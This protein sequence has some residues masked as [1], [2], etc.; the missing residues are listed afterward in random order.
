MSFA[1][2][3][4]RNRS[5]FRNLIE[6]SIKDYIYGSFE[7]RKCNQYPKSGRTRTWGTSHFWVQTQKVDIDGIRGTVLVDAFDAID[8]PFDRLNQ[9]EIKSAI[10]NGAGLLVT[11]QGAIQSPLITNKITDTKTLERFKFDLRNR[12]DLAV[13]IAFDKEGYLVRGEVLPLC[14]TAEWTA[15]GLD[16]EQR[17]VVH[18]V[19]HQAGLY[20]VRRTGIN[21]QSQDVRTRLL[22]I[23][24]ESDIP[25]I[26][27]AGKHVAETFINDIFNEGL[28]WGIRSPASQQKYDS[29]DAIISDAVLA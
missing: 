8:Q 6:M 27:Q 9:K 14:R 3:Q 10:L 4:S 11:T 18:V 5:D 16:H 2:T 17:T 12:F 19:G 25:A 21:I 7:K 26:S 15:H 22:G 29:L 1:R 13:C 23:F 24:M 20:R 28:K